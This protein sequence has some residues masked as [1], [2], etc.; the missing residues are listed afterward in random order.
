MLLL[1]DCQSVYVELKAA[2]TNDKL[3]CRIHCKLWRRW[4][5]SPALTVHALSEPILLQLGKSQ[6]R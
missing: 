3:E 4:P 6:T 2:Q 1:P 5:E